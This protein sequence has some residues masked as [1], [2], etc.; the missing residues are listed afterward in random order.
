MDTLFITNLF[1][2]N[3]ADRFY[4]FAVVLVVV[5]SIVLHELAH[6]WVALKLGDFTPMREGHM[7]GNP[8]VH[9]GP[10]ALVA[11]AIAGIS[12]GRMPVDPARL[13]GRY[14]ETWVAAA[15]PLTNLALA[16]AS[17][18]GLSVLMRQWGLEGVPAIVP[19]LGLFEAAG[20]DGLSSLQQN[21]LRL[22]AIGGAFNLVLCMF[23]LL[24][25]SPLD[26]SHILAN[27]NRRYRD[28]IGNPAHHGVHMLMFLSAFMI[29]GRLMF[30]W[31]WAAMQAYVGV[32]V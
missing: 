26:G 8:L 32:W 6:G 13:R 5:I 19:L 10:Y 15:G 7:T 23:N 31:A 27:L 1:S 2:E 14:A 4:F 11:L 9:M 28:F 22:L 24:P 30:P 3:P 21:A 18:T 20:I 12:W 25:V 16:A 17:L 29:A